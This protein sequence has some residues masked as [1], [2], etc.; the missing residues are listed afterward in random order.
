MLRI[1]HIISPVN[2]AAGTELARV[3]PVTFETMRR[4]KAAAVDVAEVGLFTAQL[5][6]DRPAVPEGFV[7]TPDLARALPD[8][9]P[10][11]KRRL[12]LLADVLQRLYEATDADI[13]I[14]TN[15]DIALM[16]GFY[17][18]VAQYAAKGYDAFAI[19]RR[20]ISSRFNSVAQLDGMYAEAGEMHPGYD[21]LVFHRALFEK[22]Q[23]GNVA[24]GLPCVDMAFLH[25]LI[26]FSKN[27]RLFTGKHLTFHI[28]MEL[29]KTW[30]NS[31]E[32]DF[33]KTEA[34]AVVKKLYPHYNI[35][36]FPGANLPFFSRHYKW[37]MNPNFH[38][39]TMLRLDR[40]QSSVPRRPRTKQPK[41]E[42]KEPRFEKLVKKIDFG[43]EY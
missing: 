2:A 26:A 13:L 17:R 25:N 41:E 36:N 16:P 22:F 6:E 9:L 15:A 21:T 29:V 43:D 38:Y 34:L 19:N 5:P 3:Q 4:A 39:P 7:P 10:A 28:G 1:A 24:V 33:N 8:V 12:P 14:Y 27:F 18:M 35:A 11:S 31:A 42:N 23:L 40:A 32:S 30:G 20:R 37:L